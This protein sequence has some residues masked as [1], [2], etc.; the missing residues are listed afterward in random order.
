M[1]Q[2]T[3]ATT[4]QKEQTQYLTTSPTDIAVCVSTVQPTKLTTNKVV[5]ASVQSALF[6]H[7]MSSSP[8]ASQ[9]SITTTGS[10]RKCL[11]EYTEF[12]SRSQRV[13][14][15]PRA[16]ILRMRLVN[17]VWQSHTHERSMPAQLFMYELLTPSYKV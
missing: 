9:N 11:K 16:F 13:M 17:V 2:L 15:F 10:T 8:H 1:N 5:Y 14:H 3:T 4:R 6:V 7:S 12:C